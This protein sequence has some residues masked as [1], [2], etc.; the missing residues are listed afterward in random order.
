MATRTPAAQL[1]AGALPGAPTAPAA[2]PP[3]SARPRGPQ[4]RFGAVHAASR[5][6]AR[7]C[8]KERVARAWPPP[9]MPIRMMFSS[10]IRRSGR[11]T[12]SPFAH[13]AVAL[14]A[15]GGIVDRE[16]VEAVL[17]IEARRGLDVEGEHPVVRMAP[18][19]ARHRNAGGEAAVERAAHVIERLDL[20]HQV[21]D[22]LR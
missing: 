8:K 3:A 4:Q 2:P 9:L 10:P 18:Q 16:A 7:F 12:V 15:P 17:D 5:V 19:A 13:L 6:R 21:V 22:A 1:G 11:R 14:D 20:E